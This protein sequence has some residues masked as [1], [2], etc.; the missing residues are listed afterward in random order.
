MSIESWRQTL[1]P[2]DA[3]VGDAIGSLERSGLQIVLVAEDGDRL[4]GTITDGDIRRGL[5]RGMTLDSQVDRIVHREPMVVPPD[6]TVEA[7][8]QI[9]SRDLD[10]TLVGKLTLEGVRFRGK[11][12]RP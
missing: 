1:L 9:S 12:R 10:G 11:R 3:T 8:L 7:A 4:V 5:L 2:D 6:L